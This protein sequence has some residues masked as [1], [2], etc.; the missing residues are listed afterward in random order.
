MRYVAPY[1]GYLIL[2]SIGGIVKFTVP[3]LLPELTCYLIDGVF[4]NEALSREQQLRQLF[5]VTGGLA[6]VFLFF[7]TP[8]T[9][10][11]HY[12]AGK[13]GQRSVF[14]LRCDLY[15]HIL[16]MSASFFSRNKSGGIVSRL[17]S[18]IEL[19]QNLVGSAMTNVWMDLASLALVLFL[20]VRIDPVLMLVAL[21]TFPPYIFF[22]RRFQRKIKTSAG[23][24]QQGISLISGNVQER[25]SGSTVV[26]AFTQEKY[27]EQSFFRDARQ[28]LSSAMRSVHLQSANAPSPAS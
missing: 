19:I 23:Q 17:I 4:L 9:Y 22:F 15:Y 25:I 12:Y 26:R 7:W 2:A 5:L 16:R 3:L 11:R 24:V 6:A 13:A 28:L 14:D 27:E 21:V 1:K 20:L 10:V 18:D 8:W